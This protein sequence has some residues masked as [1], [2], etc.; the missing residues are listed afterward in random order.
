MKT[1][2]SLLITLSILIVMLLFG[3]VNAQELEV[4][5]AKLYFT[6]NPG[7]SQTQQVLVRNKGTKEQSFIFNL[8]DW[9]TDES[10]EIKYFK[11]G[12]T[13]RS[14]TE[15]ITVSPSL[16]TLQPNE[17]GRINVTMLVPND[18]PSTKWAMLFVESAVEQTGP[19]AIDKTVQMG[20]QLSARIAIP[21]FQSPNSNT[22]YKATLEGLKE[23]L[24]GEN[25]SYTTKV[26]NLGDKILNC[27]V[28]FTFSNLTTAEEISS[29]PIEFSLLP[30]SNK[31]ISYTLD[32]KLE[33][34]KYSVAAILD[35]GYNDEL[36]GIQVDIEVK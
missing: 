5:P 30:D 10:G 27:K 12:T 19:G 28:Y 3:N 29:D 33:K 22:L 16:I 23:K 34:G 2:K 26:I 32:K 35:Y 13:P 6:A 14:C 36:E 11:P 8:G 24:D 15:W 9:L 31:D 25:R 21:I 4:S 7:S 20:M 18:N 1:M 17:S